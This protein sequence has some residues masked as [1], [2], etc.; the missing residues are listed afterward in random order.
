M[1]RPNFGS[2]GA[3]LDDVIKKHFPRHWIAVRGVSL[4]D[5]PVRSLD[6]LVATIEVLGTDRYDPKRAGIHD[7]M[8]KKFGIDLHAI[9]MMVGE[10]IYCPHYSGERLTTGSPVGEL[11]LDCY[12]GAVADRGYALRIDILTVYDLDQL[13]PAPM[14]WT[15]S[16]PQLSTEPISSKD[17]STFG[18]KY[19]EN[20]AAALLGIIRITH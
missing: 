13:V 1:P 3:K 10:K 19:P 6:D 11:L 7:E 4:Q 9:T 14:I 2:I 5:H 15:E 16:G 12:D 18:F 17:S 20:K 8:D